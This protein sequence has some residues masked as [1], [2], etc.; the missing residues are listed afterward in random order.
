[1]N[2]NVCIAAI[3]TSQI[4][5]IDC[6]QL[7]ASGSRSSQACRYDTNSEHQIVLK[8]EPSLRDKLS[9]Q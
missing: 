2:Q 9:F 6:K 3:Q 4:P 1:M 5:L 8:R 7:E